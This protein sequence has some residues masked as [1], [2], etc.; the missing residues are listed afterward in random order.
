MALFCQTLTRP[1]SVLRITPGITRIKIRYLSG[2]PKAIFEKQLICLQVILFVLSIA[3][4][5]CGT[6]RA[7]NFNF[8]L[9]T[10]PTDLVAAIVNT[11]D[12]I[13]L[14]NVLKTNIANE[15]LGNVETEESTSQAPEGIAAQ[16]ERPSDN[17]KT[18]GSI[19]SEA[20]PEESLGDSS[21]SAE[22]AATNNTIAPTSTPSTQRP[23]A[24]ET[25][26]VPTVDLQ[27][28]QTAVVSSDNSN[29][30]KSSGSIFDNVASNEDTD[31]SATTAQTQVV[32][33]SEAA[34]SASDST[35]QGKA[36]QEIVTT[37]QELAINEDEIIIAWATAWSN[38]QTEDYLSY[39]AD[40]FTPAN[41]N[42]TRSTWEQQRRKRLQNE[43]IRIIVSNAE[44]FRVEG[45]ITEIRFTQRYTSKSYRDRVI[46]SIEMTETEKGWQFL[47]EKTVEKLPFE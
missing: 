5:C 1:L 11:E 26:T 27:E 33:A 40:E 6:A 28:I 2:A 32:T 29:T 31:S 24:V 7:Q 34:L 15:I 41:K 8:D 4:S 10:I 45:D 47:S 19:F 14:T 36:A 13:S 25:P 17:A 20:E 21:E 35:S 44:V 16:T 42:L 9:I 30:T 22:L 37:E 3:I 43:D 46:K 23:K 12:D 39:Y 18:S 38:N